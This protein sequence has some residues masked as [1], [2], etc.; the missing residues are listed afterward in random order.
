MNRRRLRLAAMTVGGLILLAALP[1]GG[2]YLGRRIEWFDIDRVAV[3]GASLIPADEIVRHGGITSGQS[4]FDDSDPWEAAIR[5]HPV[6]EEVRISR[7]FPSTLEIQVREKG[8]IALLAGEML[9]LATSD[10]EILPVDP[11]EATRDLP[12]AV[13]EAPDSMR[14]P[15]EQ[16]LLA[17]T[18]RLA[19]L[20]PE[21]VSAISEL[22]LL[23]REPEVVRLQHQAG[24][25]LLPMGASPVRLAE[26]RSVLADL[27]RMSAAAVV[28]PVSSSVGASPTSEPAALPA[29]VIDLR[30]DGQVVVRHPL[31]REIS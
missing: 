24:E 12:I 7:R 15:M 11:A 18:G 16:R 21:L 29:P 27:G 20:D 8:A 31:P 14:A 25:I 13:V 23:A 2:L 26:L 19:E 9:A 10:G 5:R 1:V 22:R 30:F 3:S 17:E 6:I 28:R 4:L